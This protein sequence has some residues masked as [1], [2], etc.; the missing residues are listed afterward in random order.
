MTLK[1]YFEAINKDNKV[2]A[3]S[4][5]YPSGYVANYLDFEI[6]DNKFVIFCIDR[7]G[8]YEF[9]ANQQVELLHENSVM[10]VSEGQEDRKIKLSFMSAAVIPHPP[11]IN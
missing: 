9:D 3:I 2:F 5:K 1:N 7:G 8:P 6:K 10:V 4:L 11:E